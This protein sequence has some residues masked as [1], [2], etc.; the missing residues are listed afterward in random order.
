MT[1]VS[2]SNAKTKLSELLHR[3]RA[4]ET[5]TITDRGVPVARLV[6]L[7]GGGEVDPDARIASLE[8]RGLVTR[9]RR[10]PDMKAFL[11]AHPP[12]ELGGSV[13]E[14]LLGERRESPR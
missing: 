5:I 1:A 8:R 2:I 3:V 6:P 12:V 11:A 13:L 10:T 9:P 14:E 4:G 7:N